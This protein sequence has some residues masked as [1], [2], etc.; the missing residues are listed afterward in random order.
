MYFNL[1]S[2][3]GD[4]I[5]GYV[6]PDSFTGIPQI[7]VSSNGDELLVFEANEI[8]E[9]LIAAGRH[10]TGKCG[11]RI[12]SSV[13]PELPNLTNLEISD[14]ETGMLVYRRPR[15]D[16]IEKKILRLETHLFPLWRLDDTLEPRFQY[17][18]RGAER[19]GRESVSQMFLL[20]IINSIYVSGRILYQNYS[21]YSEKANFAT[22][23][24]LQDP[25]NEIAERL[26]I[27]SKLDDA[28]ISQLGME[29]E[30]FR[31][32]PAVE[33]AKSLSFED[34]KALTRALRSMPKD[35]AA[36]LANPIVRQLTAPTP[37]EMPRNGAVAAAL[38]CLASFA[39][40]GLRSQAAEFLH[41]VTEFLGIDASALPQI[42]QFPKV[43]A[44]GRHLKETRVVDALIEKDVELYYHVAE[45]HSK[46]E[47]A[48]ST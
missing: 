3:T 41:S 40:V 48:D 20:D 9:G 1:Q 29:R 27:L 15:K 7:R 30:R 11:F 37:D 13:L 5:V 17:F 44:L 45:A 32:G 25:H 4:V 18:A 16:F 23:T 6:V 22:V 12:D 46:L 19:Y 35:V 36:F 26:M 10:E 34:E 31:L 38:D 21:L 33:F 24:L 47:P 8:R 14:A 43:A 42:P 39:V 2:D 28:Q